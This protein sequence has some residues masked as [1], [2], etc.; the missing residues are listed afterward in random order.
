M[1]GTNTAG[2]KPSRLG[3][4]E[5][6]HA[7]M[8]SPVQRRCLRLF[9]LA[10]AIAGCLAIV[11]SCKSLPAADGGAAPESVRIQH[12]RGPLSVRESAAILEKLEGGETGVLQRH[13]AVEEAVSGSPLVLGN[14][15]TLLQDGSATY[16][17]MF[18]AIR[19]AKDHINIETYI[20]EDD[21]TGQRF[22]DLL[23]KKQAAGVQVNL[24]YDSVGSMNTPAAFFDALKKGGVRVLEFNPVNPLTARRGWELNQRDHRKLLVV[25]G[26]IAF[27]GGINISGVYSAGSAAAGDAGK[28]PLP[29]RDTQLRIEGPVVAD[30]QKLFMASWEKQRGE[31]LPRKNYFPKLAPLGDAI[32]RAISSSGTEEYSPIYVTLLSAINSAELSVYLTNAYFVPDP[33]LLEAL[34]GAAGRGVEVKL[35]LPSQ[36]DFWAVFHAGRS[37]YT[38]L[39]AAGVIIYERH[40]VLLHSKTA[41]VDGVWSSVGS[42]NLDWRSFLHNEELNAV[43]LGTKFSEQMMAAFEKDLA[44]SARI[45]LEA[46]KRRPLVTRIKEHF[47][48]MWQYW[49]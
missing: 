21:E 27:V 20:F 37:Y 13:A 38:E 41:L 23:L 49:L 29:W 14:R 44:G 15:V 24:I 42:T 19:G 28:S 4:E 39:L 33:Q 1:T 2:S 9:L 43:V 30:F 10:P 32:V 16:K 26:R 40:E 5:P 45:T 25:D 3:A 35:I 8:P 46:W 34:K 47:A 36:T 18:A 22:A 12:A 31:P 17:S 11:S 6:E 7:V 48:R